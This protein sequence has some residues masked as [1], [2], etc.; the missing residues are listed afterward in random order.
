MDVWIYDFFFIVCRYLDLAMEHNFI[1]VQ[2]IRTIVESVGRNPVGSLLVWRQFQTRWPLIESTFGRGTFT[3]GRLI[4]AAISH[5]N[6]P[7]DLKSV[8]SFFKN[9]NVGSGKR[10]LHQSLEMIQSNINFLN[11][12]D[13]ELSQWLIRNSPRCWVHITS[14]CLVRLCRKQRYSIWKLIRPMIK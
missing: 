14:F 2:D 12:Y 13:Q 4:V 5:F 3:M 1:R 10:S 9:V 8:K 11:K 7:L 6:N